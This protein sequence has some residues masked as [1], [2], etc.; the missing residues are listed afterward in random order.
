MH[1]ILRKCSLIFGKKLSKLMI[2]YVYIYAFVLIEL[3]QQKRYMLS[4]PPLVPP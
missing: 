4:D 3:K 1:K 2:S